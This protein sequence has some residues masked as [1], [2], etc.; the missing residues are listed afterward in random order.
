[1]PLEVNELRDWIL[2]NSKHIF[3]H[4]HAVFGILESFAA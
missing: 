1:M 2:K 3:I 4:H